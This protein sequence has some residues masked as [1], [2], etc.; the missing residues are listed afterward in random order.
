ML[1]GE[2]SLSC[3][4][5]L[6]LFAEFVCRFGKERKNVSGVGDCFVKKRDKK[7]T[8]GSDQACFDISKLLRICDRCHRRM[9]RCALSIMHLNRNVYV[10]NAFF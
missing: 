5:V 1:I 7:S 4:F 8:Y 2:W 6:V 9:M 10:Y 3:F